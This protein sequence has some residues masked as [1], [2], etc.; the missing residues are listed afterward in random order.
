MFNAETLIIGLAAGVLGI[1]VTVVLN[2]PIN[3]IVDHLTG[4]D[5]IAVLPQAGAAILVVI[6][7]L[8]TMVAGLIPSRAAAKKD[9]V[10]ALRTE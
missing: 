3:L 8:L 7:V 10:E 5:D 4:I 1:V 6:S 2:I 9:P